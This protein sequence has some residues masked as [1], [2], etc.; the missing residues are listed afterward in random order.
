[1]GTYGNIFMYCDGFRMCIEFGLLLYTLAV[2][3]STT[4]QWPAEFVF[5]SSG[6]GTPKL[7]ELKLSRQRW[8]LL[9]IPYPR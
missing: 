6:K 3:C 4:K 8:K 1:M 2:R 7:K 5:W 9:T